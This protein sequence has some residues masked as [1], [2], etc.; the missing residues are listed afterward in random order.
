MGGDGA[1]D[2]SVHN[3]LLQSLLIFGMCLCGVDGV[4]SSSHKNT[5]ILTA[6]F[7]SES[8]KSI[9]ALTRKVRKEMEEIEEAGGVFFEDPESKETRLYRVKFFIFGDLKFTHYVF[10]LQGQSS[11]YPCV[12]CFCH[13][14][15]LLNF[16]QVPSI[17]IGRTLSKMM[18]DGAKGEKLM[19][20]LGIEKKLETE[21]DRFLATNGTPKKKKR[22]QYERQKIRKPLNQR[23]Q[24]LFN[25]IKE[26]LLLIAPKRFILDTLHTLLRIVDFFEFLVE[27]EIQKYPAR[28][29]Q[30]RNDYKRALKDLHVHKKIT[31]FIGKEA[32]KIFDNC[33]DLVTFLP[34]ASRPKLIEFCERFREIVHYFNSERRFSQQEALMYRNLCLGFGQFL[35]INFPISNFRSN[36]YIH[37]LVYHSWELM[38]EYGNLG[39]FSA[40]GLKALNA[41]MKTTRKEH[42]AFGQTEKK[43]EIVQLVEYNSSSKSPVVANNTPH[44]Q[45]RRSPTCSRCKGTWPGRKGYGRHKNCSLAAP[46]HKPEWPAF[47]FPQTFDDVV[48][49]NRAPI[50][51]GSVPRPEKPKRN[52]PEEHELKFSKKLD[53][54]IASVTHCEIP[55]SL[56]PLH[57]DAS[58]HSENVQHAPSL[59][60]TPSRSSSSKVLPHSALQAHYE[61]WS[62]VSPPSIPTSSVSVLA[63]ES[64]SRASES[65]SL[66]NQSAGSCA[67]SSSSP[68]SSPS[69]QL[70]LSSASSSSV[71]VSQS[72]MQPVSPPLSPPMNPSLSKAAPSFSSLSPNTYL[73]RVPDHK[74]PVPR[75]RP[76]S[77][78]SPSASMSLSPSPRRSVSLT[79]SPEKASS[80]SSR[81]HRSGSSESFRS[82]ST[83]PAKRAKAT[84]GQSYPSPA[85]PLRSTISESTRKVLFLSPSSLQKKKKLQP[86]SP[87]SLSPVIRK[88]PPPS[89]PRPLL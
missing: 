64:T 3:P 77:A 43:P 62:T 81:M 26:P 47:V 29:E 48:K 2:A 84:H 18:A 38:Y 23:S 65:P 9:S 30:L 53:V 19:E 67:T 12:Y 59:F 88:R 10:G 76:R 87:A 1:S 52:S 35:N 70:S 40:K 57:T 5:D 28:A 13:R 58:F 21:R 85:T 66:C 20:E 22:H 78:I 72:A 61:A 39:I 56:V 44:P 54:D 63:S 79:P 60:S 42:I 89:F 49:M 71:C 45:K 51:P 50:V 33:Y 46:V 11:S 68:T 82:P 75:K 27:L 37:S 41:I 55:Q 83:S 73:S 8:F 25:Q 24:D 69:S 36:L 6:M 16:L 17:P 86:V 4:K 34:E 31:G 80:S 74:K 15:N 14:D 7:E 32:I